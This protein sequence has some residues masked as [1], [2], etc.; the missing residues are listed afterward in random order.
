MRPSR[1]VEN[2]GGLNYSCSACGVVEWHNAALLMDRPPLSYVLAIR[3][4]P[5]QYRG[6][7]Y[8]FWDYCPATHPAGGNRHRAGGN[9]S[10]TC[11]LV[12]AMSGAN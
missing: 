1:P 4:T 5:R 12:S 10:L 9:T 7:P 2:S 6:R 3:G 8:V 11:F